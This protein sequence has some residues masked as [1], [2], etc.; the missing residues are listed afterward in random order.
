M[1]SLTGRNAG[2]T[3]ACPCGCAGGPQAGGALVAGHP[4][5]GWIEPDGT[6]SGRGDWCP[7]ASAKPTAPRSPAPGPTIGIGRKRRRG[8]GAPS[9]AAPEGSAGQRGVAAA[10]RARARVPLRPPD[11]LPAAGLTPPVGPAAQIAGLERAR[12]A[13]PAQV[14]ATVAEGGSTPGEPPARAAEGTRLSAG[15]KGSVASRAAQLPPG[16][17]SG[18]GAGAQAPAGEGVLE[19]AGGFGAGVGQRGG[20]GR[21]SA[22]LER[23]KGEAEPDGSSPTPAEAAKKPEEPPAPEEGGEE[24]EEGKPGEAPCDCECVCEPAPTTVTQEIALS[25]VGATSAVNVLQPPYFTQFAAPASQ[26]AMV[27]GGVTGAV[28]FQGGAFVGLP[29]AALGAQALSLRPP[30]IGLVRPSLAGPALSHFVEGM[31]PGSAEAA[32][33]AEGGRPFVSD[34]FARLDPLGR[35]VV[36]PQEPIAGPLAGGNPPK[37]PEGEDDKDEDGEEGEDEAGGGGG[38]GQGLIAPP[39]GLEHVVAPFGS[40]PEAPTSR[41]EEPEPRFPPL[42]PGGTGP[43][44]SAPPVLAPDIVAPRTRPDVLGGRS[45]DQRRTQGFTREDLTRRLMGVPSRPAAKS[46]FGSTAE[47]L[48]LRAASISTQGGFGSGRLTTEPEGGWMDAGAGQL[49]PPGAVQ[50]PS[51]ALAEDFGPKGKPSVD[52]SGGGAGLGLLDSGGD[53]GSVTAPG[54]AASASDL[55]APS[56]LAGRGVGDMGGEFDQEIAGPFPAQFAGGGSGELG[57]RGGASLAAPGASAGLLPD[58]ALPVMGG[59]PIAFGEGVGQGGGGGGGSLSSVAAAAIHTTA[60]GTELDAAGNAVVEAQRRLA[61]K[62]KAIEAALPEAKALVAKYLAVPERERGKGMTREEIE[63]IHKAQDLVTFGFKAQE[64]QR[65][66]GQ[67]EANYASLDEALWASHEEY[68]RLRATYL[69]SNPS[70][71]EKRL[72]EEIA[73]QASD[74]ARYRASRDAIVRDRHLEQATDSAAAQSMRELNGA[75]NRGDGAAADKALAGNLALHSGRLASLAAL[76][77]QRSQLEVQAKGEGFTAEQRRELKKLRMDEDRRAKARADTYASAAKAVLAAAAAVEKEARRL[78]KSPDPEDT[79]RAEALKAKAEALKEHGHALKAA[80]KQKPPPSARDM[81]E[82]LKP[83]ESPGPKEP[84][85]KKEPKEPEDQ[86]GEEPKQPPQVG[87]D[88]RPPCPPPCTCKP[89][90]PPGQTCKCVKAKA[91]VVPEGAGGGGGAGGGAGGAGAGQGPLMPPGTFAPARAE[92]PPAPPPAPVPPPPGSDTRARPVAPEGTEAEV[93]AGS[94]T[95]TAKV[96]CKPGKKVPFSDITFPRDVPYL[97]LDGGH[98][99]YFYDGKS[100]WKFDVFTSS[101]L[102][103]KL[104]EAEKRGENIYIDAEVLFPRAMVECLGEVPEAAAKWLRGISGLLQVLQH[105]SKELGALAGGVL[106]EVITQF[107]NLLERIG[108]LVDAVGDAIAEQIVALL[109]QGLALLEEVLPPEWME[110][111]VAVFD[112]LAEG[113]QAVGEVQESVEEALDAQLKDLGL[114]KNHVRGLRALLKLFSAAGRIVGLGGTLGR[115]LAAANNDWRSR[116]SRRSG[117]RGDGRRKEGSKDGDKGERNR[118]GVAPASRRTPYDW[119]PDEAA[120]RVDEL[121]VQGHGPQRHEGQVDAAQHDARVL[122]GTDP[123][124]GQPEVHL[125]GRKAGQLKK[126]PEKSSSFRSNE[127][128]AQAEAKARQS[129]EFLEGA[130]EAKPRIEVKSVSLEDALGSDYLR[131]VEGRTTV[132]VPGGSTKS[133]DFSGGRVTAYYERN[134]RGGYDLVTMFPEGR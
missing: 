101:G 100:L 92:P 86:K 10:E 109:M 94:G 119:T 52:K 111:V 84:E 20:G 125:T 98:Y 40:V 104:V 118:S 116:R 105:F 7:A 59:L 131:H 112:S 12:G 134:A 16:S 30:P 85:E 37:A 22:E 103:D 4:P 97:L 113:L 23:G 34:L 57:R 55:G 108:E 114:N 19:Q 17:A 41:R 54:S 115:K 73:R 24:G 61:E 62:K 75:R 102:R 120:H 32:F 76:D 36:G 78:A 47:K 8:R 106:Q 53:L 90:C 69:E 87:D 132:G 95:T 82:H 81:D 29:N 45:G 2:S 93:P 122:K 107:A 68:Q 15:P 50:S 64:E 99:Y 127:A 44:L 88:P 126:P 58:G 129:R 110:K 21:D 89:P 14:P 42:R 13:S 56:D 49:V 18:G 117:D 51:A 70:D 124:T 63:R 96:P 121:K 91:A 46:A 31:V 11:G 66:L 6:R 3:E 33:E 65:A 83:K 39:L 123:A 80:S 9:L 74:A 28:A 71:G 130:A 5:K 67:A 79:A 27:A 77:H 26:A 43:G 60:L 48:R 72:Q 1:P 128:Y 35:V 38:K 25:Q 133:I